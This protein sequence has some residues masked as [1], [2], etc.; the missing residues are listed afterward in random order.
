[1]TRHSGKK[2]HFLPLELESLRDVENLRRNSHALLTALVHTCMELGEMWS[3][4]T[5]FIYLIL[6]VIG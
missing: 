3:I 2:E 4:C 1:M 6:T 5:M